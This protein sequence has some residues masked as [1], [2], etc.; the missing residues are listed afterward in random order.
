MLR[1][2]TMGKVHELKLYTMAEAWAEQQK[3]SDFAGMDFDERFGLLVDAEHLARDNRRL[4]RLMRAA[5]LR[6]SNASMEDVDTPGP[7]RSREGYAATA[8]NVLLG[9][10][11]PQRDHHGGHGRG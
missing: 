1:E 4:A 6:I 8:R 9:G 10:A 7:K 3:S 5:R 11:A 2:P